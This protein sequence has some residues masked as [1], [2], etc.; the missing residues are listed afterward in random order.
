M[1][2]SKNKIGNIENS[3]IEKIEQTNIEK[4]EN[5][6]TNTNI[7]N[8]QINLIV[9][10]GDFTKVALSHDLFPDYIVATKKMHNGKY[11]L[12]SKPTSEEATKKYPHTFKS[13][14]QVLDERYKNIKD[15]KLLLDMLQYADTPVEIKVLKSEQYLGGIIDPYP[16]PELSLMQEDTKTY[17]MPQKKK[18]PEIKFK[19][20]IKFENSKFKLR[21]IELK[22]TKQFSSKKFILDNYAQNDSHILIQLE[23]E[24]ISEK[25]L[26]CKLNYKINVEKMKF[27]T[28]LHTY[29]LFVL[30]LFKNGYLIYDKKNEKTML[31]GKVK[32]DKS[33][34]I[35][36]L[37]SYLQLIKMIIQIEKYFNVEFDIPKEIPQDDIDT[38]VKLYKKII[39]SKKRVRA[40]DYSFSVLKKDTNTDLDYLR[41][42]IQTDN[43]GIIATHNDVIYNILGKDIKINE[44]LEKYEGIKCY[45]KDEIKKFIDNYDSLKEDYELRIKM[46][47]A[48]SKSFYKYTKIIK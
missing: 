13:S 25:E 12:V 19:V 36:R 6:I 2:D 47:P 42:L 24:F 20:D 27:S 3:K 44:I 43:I 39:E 23:L 35:K 10:G 38:I 30:N 8:K 7:T 32:D 1:L 29:T 4:Q 15:P 48:E 37:E 17:I 45:N 31:S 41:Q 9:D 14:I 16:D 26:K 5:Y 22:L 34:E 33:E 18:L 28:T 21:N 40:I 11:T 46:I